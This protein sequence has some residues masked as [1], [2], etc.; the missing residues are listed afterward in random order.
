[1]QHPVALRLLLVATCLTAEH[2]ISTVFRSTGRRIAMTRVFRWRW[3]SSTAFA[4]LVLSAVH[5]VLPTQAQ[6]GCNSPWVHHSRLDLS[7][8][9]SSLLDSSF[10]LLIAEPWS[11]QP[12]DRRGPCAGGACSRPREL[13]PGPT[14]LVSFH[15]ERWGDV[16]AEPSP[17][18][19]QSREFSPEDNQRRSSRLPTSIER[20]P[21]IYSAG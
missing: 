9:E 21:R 15:G 3:V 5:V 17:A 1:V 2:P 18:L 10:Q 12:L 14:I 7:Q 6:A 20:P 11:R 4:W 16:P 13:P 19:P 8:F